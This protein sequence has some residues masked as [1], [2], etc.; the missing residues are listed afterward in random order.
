MPASKQSELPGQV[1]LTGMFDMRNF[2]DLMFPLIARERLGGMDIVPVSP[3]GRDTGF[4]DALP[5]IPLA[6]MITG[7]D[8][9]QGILIGGGYMIHGHK[10]HFLDEYAAD[11]LR[12]YAG[13][14]LWLGA[15]LTRPLFAIFPSHGI[16]RGF[17]TPLHAVN[18]RLVNSA[19]RAASYCSVRD[20]GSFELLGSDGEVHTVPDPVAGIMRLWPRNALVAPFANLIARKG[21][22]GDAQY[23][24]LHFRNRSSGEAWR[25]SGCSS[26]RI[27]LPGEGPGAHPGRRGA[28]A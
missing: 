9:A 19:V 14:G 12:D 5:S 24:A 15:T 3:T 28:N 22:R 27:I 21:A 18:A 8:A 26:N 4:V 7:R 10:M 2:G 23:L 16:H 20:K 6:Q 25:G 1:F 13:P 17:R 11:G